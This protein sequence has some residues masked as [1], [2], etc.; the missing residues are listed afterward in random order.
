MEDIKGYKK[1]KTKYATFAC[2]ME[3]DPKD[4]ETPE[5]QRH[6]DLSFN[7]RYDRR[8][9][10]E[11]RWAEK[12]FIEDAIVPKYIKN[13]KYAGMSLAEYYKTRGKFLEEDVDFYK[14]SKASAI[15][16]AQEKVVKK[17]PVKLVEKE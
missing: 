8:G 15:L 12:V 14:L 1:F 2:L 10:E 6:T 9:Q 16:N 3:N 13:K 4:P 17:S 11:I 7:T 5:G